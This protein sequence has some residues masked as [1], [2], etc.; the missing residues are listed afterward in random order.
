MEMRRKG[1]LGERRGLQCRIGRRKC[2]EGCRVEGWVVKD[3]EKK[4]IEG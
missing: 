1:S 4:G 2:S 3:Q